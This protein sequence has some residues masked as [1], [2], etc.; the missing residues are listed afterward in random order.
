[1]IVTICGSTRFKKE[2]M[3]VAKNLTLQGHIV[4][5]PFVFHHQEEEEIPMETL[6]RLDNL[7]KEKINM[8]DAIFV[9]NVDGYI[10]ES[11]YGE[12]DWA[13]RMKKEI[14]FLVD[15]PK[16]ETPE[17]NNDKSITEEEPVEEVVTESVDAETPNK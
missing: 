8:S 14:Y 3:N 1:M 6:I 12:I 17:S 10:G 2:I 7:H 5:A 4:L 11:T 16:P 15:P 13:N 9:V